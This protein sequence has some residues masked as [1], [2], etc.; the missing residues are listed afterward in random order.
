[1][2]IGGRPKIE[3][4][5][6]PTR[7]T[8]NAEVHECL[9]KIS[10]QGGNRSRFVEMYMEAPCRQ[11][12]PGPACKRVS[13]IQQ[14]LDDGLHS[15]LQDGDYAGMQVLSKI[16]EAIQPAVAVCGLDNRSRTLLATEKSK[17]QR[18]M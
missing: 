3:G 6:T 15:A 12:D 5:H 16:R 8:L 4:G 10:D 2:T 9:R 14:L 13:M 7:L 17:D 1:M 18:I 11:L